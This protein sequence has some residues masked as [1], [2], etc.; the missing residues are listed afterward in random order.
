MVIGC[1]D[2]NKLVSGKG[3]ERLQKA[4]IDVIV[5]I[6]EDE[7]R[8]HHKRF[9]TVQEKKRPYII[10]KWA[11]TKDGFI[12]PKLDSE[13]VNL[14]SKNNI[15]KAKNRLL[16]QKKTLRKDE[17]LKPVQRKPIWISNKYSQQLVHKLRSKEHAILVGTNTV[18]ADNPKLNVR[19]FT[20]NNP[21]RIVLDNN[22]RIPKNVNVYDKTQKTIFIKSNGHQS[23]ENIIVEN[24]KGLKSLG[25]F[26]EID[27]TENVAEQICKIL[28]KHNIQ[29][30]II[31]GGTQ[32]LQTFIDANLWDE[33]KVFIGETSFKNGIKA[34]VLSAKIT[35]EKKIKNDI[36]K[37]YTND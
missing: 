29:S 21:I 19:S 6:L 31:E 35:S 12:Y 22:L 5:G 9:F 33:A 34:P 23:I 24:N 13:S 28:Q 30:V 3:I 14:D 32:T 20:G 26:E 8:K 16:Q 11:E 36:L 2:S 15:Y 27:F 17:T 1:S 10:L 25:N 18:I 4:G 37:T 7:C